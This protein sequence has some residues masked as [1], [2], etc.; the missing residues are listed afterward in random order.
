MSD[1][2][3]ALMALDWEA[4]GALAGTPLLLEDAIAIARAAN[5]AYKVGVAKRRTPPLAPRL[6]SN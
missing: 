6:Q 1:G 3:A 4:D 2:T 5:E